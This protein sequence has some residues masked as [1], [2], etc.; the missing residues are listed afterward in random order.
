M[1]E[2]H[3]YQ[4]EQ[5][6]GYGRGIHKDTALNFLNVAKLIQFSMLES[7][8]IKNMKRKC[9]QSHKLEVIKH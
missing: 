7:N 9:I 8:N 2:T 4:Q 6:E 5:V 3:S 1:I